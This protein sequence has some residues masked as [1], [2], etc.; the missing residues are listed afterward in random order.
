MSKGLLGAK[1]HYCHRYPP[2]GITEVSSSS[3]DGKVARDTKTVFPIVGPDLWCGEF[4]T[5]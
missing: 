5:K 4:R 2:S 1:L 3:Y